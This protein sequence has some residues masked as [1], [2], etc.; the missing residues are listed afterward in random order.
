MASA[1]AAIRL[2]GDMTIQNAAE[3]RQAL[4]AALPAAEA[5]LALDLSRVDGFDSAGVQ[6]LLALRHSLQARGAELTLAGATQAIADALGVY[7]LDCQLR[8]RLGGAA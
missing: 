5:G 2:E 8:S 6:L 3:Q 7:G 1:T 4:L